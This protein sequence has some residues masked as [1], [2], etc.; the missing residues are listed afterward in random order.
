MLIKQNTAFSVHNSPQSAARSCDCDRIAYSPWTST[1]GL[2][3]VRLQYC[4]KRRRSQS[5]SYAE[6]REVENTVY[7]ALFVPVVR[8][9]DMEYALASTGPT[10]LIFRYIVT[11][12]VKNAS[13]SAAHSSR[14]RL[15]MAID[16]GHV[17]SASTVPGRDSNEQH[18]PEGDGSDAA[19]M[20]AT[21]IQRNRRGQLCRREQKTQHHAAAKVQGTRR[22]QLARK[23]KKAEHHAATKVQAI[24]RG[25]RARKSELSIL[26]LLGGQAERVARKEAETLLRKEAVEMDRLVIAQRRLLARRH[27][28]AFM[29]VLLKEHAALER[30]C[31]AC[32]KHHVCNEA[33]LRIQAAFRLRPFDNEA[34]AA[35]ARSIMKARS[36]LR[37]NLAEVY[38]HRD[39]VQ[40]QAVRFFDLVGPPL[41]KKIKCL[42]QRLEDSKRVEEH[43][44]RKSTRVVKCTSRRD[45]NMFVVRSTQE[46]LLALRKKLG[47]L[48][49]S[50]LKFKDK[51]EAKR[52]MAAKDPYGDPGGVMKLI[53]KIHKQ[54]GSSNRSP[55]S[56][57]KFA[58]QWKAAE[59]KD[60]LRE[61]VAPCPAP[62]NAV[63]ELRRL[64]E[65]TEMVDFHSHNLQQI[66]SALEPLRTLGSRPRPSPAQI[67]A[68]PKIDQQP[69][70]R[71]RQQKS[72]AALKGANKHTQAIAT[73]RPPVMLSASRQHSPSR[74]TLVRDESI[75][76]RFRPP[77]GAFFLSEKIGRAHV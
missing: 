40:A 17:S 30:W 59:R 27:P 74:M 14:F 36:K 5:Q 2:Y 32:T 20:A 11:N 70:G 54:D 4:I 21:S 44:S 23:E 77:G 15:K 34:Q 72:A 53:I 55:R 47:E 66:R 33:A 38:D 6:I 24:Q 56:L 73:L 8:V 63:E 22:G 42:H 35:S 41:I 65:E 45:S 69:I 1:V 57:S 71:R 49:E 19:I 46:E 29:V 9:S 26:D 50:M 18:S 10:S 7:R 64:R 12:T 25:K 48:E 68:V 37:R 16:A 3:V 39:E 31:L 75:G 13:H 60:M 28:E 62:T 58:T 52:L 67:M 76:R 51:K 61:A 43:G